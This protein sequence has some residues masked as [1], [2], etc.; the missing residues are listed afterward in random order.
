[1]GPRPVWTQWPAFLR[2]AHTCINVS[3]TVA[4]CTKLSNH[5]SHH[6]EVGKGPGG[7]EVLVGRVMSLEPGGQEALMVTRLPP[8]KLL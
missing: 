7:Q 1:M 6:L 4:S 2:T 5:N 8:E 3:N